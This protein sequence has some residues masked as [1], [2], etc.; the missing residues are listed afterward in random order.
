MKTDREVKSK[1]LCYVHCLKKVFPGFHLYT[2]KLPKLQ[3]VW[4]W[5]RVASKI[6]GLQVSEFLPKLHLFGNCSKSAYVKPRT[7]TKSS[8]IQKYEGNPQQHPHRLQFGQ[9]YSIQM[10]A[11]KD[12]LETVYIG[13]FKKN[14]K[15]GPFWPTNS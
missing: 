7:V 1:L 14:Y 11:G 8:I 15:C 5:L 4:A 13:F 3:A 10:K 2:I 6:W 12:F 9:F